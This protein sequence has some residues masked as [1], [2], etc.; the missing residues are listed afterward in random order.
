MS[1]NGK[2][3]GRSLRLAA[4]SACVLLFIPFLAMQFTEEV[5]WGVE[6]FLAAAALLSAAFSAIAVA[7]TRLH[8]TA[9][10]TWVVAGILVALAIIWAELAVGLFW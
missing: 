8:G 1:M 9:A 5:A 4:A 2:S 6:D 3:L 7:A 10:R